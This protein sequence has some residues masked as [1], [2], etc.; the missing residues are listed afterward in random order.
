MGAIWPLFLH[1][2]LHHHLHVNLEHFLLQ[3]DHHIDP[4]YFETQ[5]H[6]TACS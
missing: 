6:Q 5:Q 2:Y 3:M 4:E 1:V